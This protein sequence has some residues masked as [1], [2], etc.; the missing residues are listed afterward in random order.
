MEKILKCRR[1]EPAF[2]RDMNRIR[3][4]RGECAGF[5]I[6]WRLATIALYSQ[7]WEMRKRT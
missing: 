3:Y 1:N 4:M 2:Y 6:M 7:I 5:V